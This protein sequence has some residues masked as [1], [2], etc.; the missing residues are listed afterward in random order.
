MSLGVFGHLLPSDS[1][2]K[3]AKKETCGIL[4]LRGRGVDQVSG[5]R[6]Q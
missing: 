6:M 4:S 2:Q 3:K 5:R 1:V